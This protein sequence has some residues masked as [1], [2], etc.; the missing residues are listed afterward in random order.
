M[1]AHGA[2]AAATAAE[3]R[4]VWKAATPARQDFG[5]VVSELK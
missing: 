5:V 2:N 1:S 4:S 3:L